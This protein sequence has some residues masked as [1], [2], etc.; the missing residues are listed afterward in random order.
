MTIPLY[1]P[2]HHSS[3]VKTIL[4]DFKGYKKCGICIYL[5]MPLCIWE[6]ILI[7]EI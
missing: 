7:L 6:E 2:K 5:P 4:L 1:L 3:Q